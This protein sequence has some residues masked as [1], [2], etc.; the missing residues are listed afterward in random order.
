MLAVKID[1]INNTYANADDDLTMLSHYLEI[2]LRLI[3]PFNHP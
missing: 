3:F 1:L 2:Y